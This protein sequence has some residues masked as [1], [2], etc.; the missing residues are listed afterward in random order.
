MDSEIHRETASKYLIEPLKLWLQDQGL[1]AFVGGNSFVYYPTP[2]NSKGKKI[3]R[4]G[5]DFYVVLGGQARGQSKWVVWEEGNRYPTLAIELTSPS[6]VARDRG[7][8]FQIY[9]SQWKMPDYFLFDCEELQLEGFHL[10]RSAYV[11]TKPDAEGRHAC[12]TLPLKLGVHQGWLRFFTLDG[13]L[14]PTGEERGAALAEQARS[15]AAH[16][17]SEAEEARSE[18]EQAKQRAARL[19]AQLRALGLEP[20]TL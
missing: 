6:T 5:P 3:K 15:E 20:D 7:P 13:Q 18:A 16:A 11:A 4:L 9:R 12:Q 17:R 19:E 14:L 2:K 8:K 10:K 1:E